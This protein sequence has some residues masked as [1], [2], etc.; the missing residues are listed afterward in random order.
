M[1]DSPASEP[2]PVFVCDCEGW[3]RSA[4]EAEFYKEHGSKRYCV[5]HFPGKEKSAEFKKVFEKKLERKDFN[6]SGVWFPDELSF[7]DFNFSAEADFRGAT[8]SAEADFG[9][10]TF[11]AKADFGGSTFIANANFNFAN[12]S[13]EADFASVTFGGEADFG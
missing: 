3:M 1:P 13:A 12:F 6:F 10:A 7:R 2:E 4:C 5:L 11:R 9:S 8:F